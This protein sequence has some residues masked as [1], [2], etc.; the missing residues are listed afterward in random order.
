[1]EELGTLYDADVPAVI[2][3]LKA[4]TDMYS[5]EVVKRSQER[6]QNGDQ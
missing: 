3:K 6:S 4:R 1:M 5:A 2:T